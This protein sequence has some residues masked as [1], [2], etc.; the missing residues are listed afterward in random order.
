MTHKNKRLLEIIFL[1]LSSILIIYIAATFIRPKKILSDE[2]IYL[3]E[4]RIEFGIVVDSFHVVNK[5]IQEGEN[6][7]TI[8][9]RYHIDGTSIDKLNKASDSVFDV[10]KIRAGNRYTVLCTNDKLQKAL[11]FIY[12]PSD[13]SYV[14]FNLKDSLNVYTGQKQVKVKTQ[15]TA[16][17]IKGSLWGTFERLKID[18]NLAISLSEIFQWTIDFYAIKEGDQF[19]VSYDQLYVG[20]KSIG[21]GRIHSAWFYHNGKPYFA[22]KFNDNGVTGYFDETGNSL[23]RGFLKAPL[24]F[25]R[26][27]SYFT[28]SR[29]HPILHIF[30]AH[31]GVDYAAPRGTPVHAIGNAVVTQAGFIGGGG[32]AIRLKHT[33]SFETTYMHLS[34]FAAGIHKGVHVNQGQVIGYVGTSGLATGP[35]LDFRVYRS[36]VAIDPLKLISPPGTSVSKNNLPLFTKQ[37]LTEKAKLDALKI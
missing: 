1:V 5:E 29:Y 20:N 26:I 21:L 28:N 25:T 34:A 32:N 18:P 24:K 14:V 11:Y 13:T 8:L 9:S 7:S 12:E 16:G 23:K 10:R 6:L 22:F 27:S 37:I 3:P 4:P 33:A 19:K 35:H 17:I 36:G 31:H 30:R 15:V 2:T